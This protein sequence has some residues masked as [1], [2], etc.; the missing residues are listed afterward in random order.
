MASSIPKA[1]KKGITDAWASESNSKIALLTNSF[2]NTT[3]AYTVYGDLTNECTG[4]GYTAG[5]AT[6]TGKASANVGEN[7]KMTATATQWTTATISNIKYAVW[8]E[9]GTTKSIRAIFELPAT[10]SVV[11]G[12]FT[13]TWNSAGVVTVS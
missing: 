5:G 12:T 4:T 10:Y 6:L 3:G 8:Y 1:V 7:A 13:L 2:P 11:T 9:D